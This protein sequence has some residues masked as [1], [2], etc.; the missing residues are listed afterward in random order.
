[1]PMS[2]V[3]IFF[4]NILL[5]RLERLAGLGDGARGPSH[6]WRGCVLSCLSD[7]R[8]PEPFGA[9]VRRRGFVSLV[10]GA[11]AWPL[12]ARAPGGS[13]PVIGYLSATSL[14]HKARMD[15]F[16]RGLKEA[17]FVQGQNVAIEY[18]SAD[19]R[20]DRLPELA[21]DLIARRVDVILASGA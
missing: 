1:S 14:G 19:G 8:E 21:A 9:S 10:G 13:M 2:N 17:G 3:L 4:R 16:H 12:A 15:A 6:A 18:R 5:L 7:A 11:V 20:Y